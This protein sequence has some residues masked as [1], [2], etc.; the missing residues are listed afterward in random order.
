VNLS[1]EAL[2]FHVDSTIVTIGNRVVP[3]PEFQTSGA[4]IAPSQRYFYWFP[5]LMNFQLTNEIR[6]EMA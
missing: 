1:P 3:N 6:G 5:W 2:R 4:V